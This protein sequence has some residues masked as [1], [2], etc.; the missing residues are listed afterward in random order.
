MSRTMTI[1]SCSAAKPA[2]SSSYILATRP[3][4]FCRPSRVGSSPIADRISRTARS[5][6]SLSTLTVRSP[7]RPR[8]YD[9]AGVPVDRGQV[10]VPLPHVEA[11]ADHEFGRDVETDVAQV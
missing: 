9:R 5:I 1:S 2:K 10:A 8:L 6:R 11:V 3:G 4:V 7:P